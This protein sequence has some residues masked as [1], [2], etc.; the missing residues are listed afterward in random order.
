MFL[1]QDS[2]SAGLQAAIEASI[3]PDM[4]RRVKTSLQETLSD[5]QKEYPEEVAAEDLEGARRRAASDLSDYVENKVPSHRGSRAGSR[6]NSCLVTPASM[7]PQSVPEDIVVDNSLPPLALPP[8]VAEEPSGEINAGDYEG[9][10]LSH[11][12]LLDHE[13]LMM[14]IY[15]SQGL[16]FD[17]VQSQARTFLQAIGLRPHDLGVKNTDEEGRTLVNQCFYLSISHAYLGYLST[18]D[19]VCGLALHL[20][21]AI[22]AAVLA[23]RPSWAA[24][25]GAGEA[26]ETEA[27]AFAD[28]LPIA[29][30]A[31]KDTGECNITAE[32]AVCILDSVAGHVEVYLGPKYKSHEDRE[33]QRRSLALL[34]YT[35]GHYQCLV[36]DDEFGSDVNLTYEEF[37][38]LLTKHGVNFIETLE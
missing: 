22:E 19:E 33:A 11:D 9:A 1:L 14:A 2:D 34:W 24:G 36:C 6:A 17:A 3:G 4:K 10:F 28:F 5:L 13:Q 26:G 35:P 25:T 29:M 8:A 16:D 31:G 32:L 30:H 37:K 18:S 27:M 15:L 23:A 7:A 12:G 20:K 38:E 21:R